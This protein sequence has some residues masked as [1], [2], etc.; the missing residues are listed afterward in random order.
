[1]SL[2]RKSLVS[3]IFLILSGC[4]QPKM[5]TYFLL[6]PERIPQT[7]SICSSPGSDL[8]I[9]NPEDCAAAFKALPIVKS[10]LALFINNP[11]QFAM[12]IMNA[13]TQLLALKKAHRL[14]LE[15]SQKSIVSKIEQ[16]IKNQEIQIQSR[17]AIIRL[18]K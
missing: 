2:V 13:E 12:A 6:H 8:A 18:V 11:T 3:L 7:Y 1:M 17:F 15:N 5:V 14:A 16:D 10:N 4:N 9:K